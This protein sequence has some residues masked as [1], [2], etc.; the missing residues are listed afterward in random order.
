MRNAAL[1]G[2]ATIEHG[3][4]GTPEVFRLM[5]DRGVALCPTLAATNAIARYRGWN[6]SAPEPD[7]VRTLRASFSAALAAGVTIC[8]GGDV[9]VYAHGE[10][11]REMELMVAYGM[12]PVDVLIAATSG[13]A[14]IFRLNDRG[15]VRPG[16]L[17]DLVAVEGDP[18][19][20]IGAVRRVALVMKGGEIVREPR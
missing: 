14:R 6:G 5:R 17:A 11:A 2:A 1:A 19:R 13:N 15:A 18:T 20:D 7:A 4:A 3:S 8:M 10:N 9:G 12:G 16:L